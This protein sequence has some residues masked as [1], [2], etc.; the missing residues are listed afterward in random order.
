MIYEPYKKFSPSYVGLAKTLFG[1]GAASYAA[2]N[3]YLNRQLGRSGGNAVNVSYVRKPRRGSKRTFAAKVRSL[4][5]YKHYPINDNVNTANLVANTVYTTSV[6]TKVVQGDANY[7][8]TG[9]AIQLVALKIKGVI[10]SA[11]AAGAYGYRVIVGYSTKQ[12]NLSGSAAGLGMTDIFI[13]GTGTNWSPSA[14]INPKAFTCL[15]D[16]MID[17]NS[18]V[19]ATS[20]LA[21]V[22][23]KVPLS[24][25]FDYITDGSVYGKTRNL[26]IIVIAAVIGGVTG[27][28]S[29]GSYAFNS[30][31]IFQDQ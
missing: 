9:D 22:D 20:D 25:K 3:R 27:T 5:S 11:T 24:G 1:G 17:I 29:C 19:T 12:Y 10:S 16:S 14:I 13:P 6:T 26:Y 31:L 8:R 21:Q 28:T 15:H 30:D 4:E 23:I 2:S 18:Q 7:Q